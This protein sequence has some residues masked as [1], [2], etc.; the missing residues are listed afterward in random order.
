MWC[1]GRF[2]S[3]DGLTHDIYRLVTVG[4]YFTD[5]IRAMT[6]RPAFSPSPLI[7]TVMLLAMMGKG[8]RLKKG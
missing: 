7:D 5:T 6:I 3:T 4:L 1:A 2:H 8:H